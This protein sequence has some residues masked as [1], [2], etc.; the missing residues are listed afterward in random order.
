M[1]ANWGWFQW[2]V[3]TVFVFFVGILTTLVVISEMRVSTSANV[4]YAEIQQMR[5]DESVE[6]QEQEVRE[7][8]R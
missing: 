7:A 1:F 4:K 6:R 5:Y 3:I 8:I 2:T